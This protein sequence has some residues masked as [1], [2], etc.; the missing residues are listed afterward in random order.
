MTEKLMRLPWKC[1]RVP[2]LM[3]DEGGLQ[4][5]QQEKGRVRRD[6]GGGDRPDGEGG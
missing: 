2:E 4:E 6:K 5:L 3:G 1:F